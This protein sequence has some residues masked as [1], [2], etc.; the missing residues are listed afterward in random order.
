MK[1]QTCYICTQA[2]H[3]KTK[4]GLVRGCSC[5]GTAGFV[6]VSCLAEQAKILL[7]EAEEKNMDQVVKAKL[8]LRWQNCRLCGQL[9]NGV[10]GCALG[11]ACWKTYGTADASDI[12]YAEKLLGE[13]AEKA[14]RI[15]GPTRGSVVDMF[16]DLPVFRKIAAHIRA[17]HETP[18]YPSEV[19]FVVS[20]RPAK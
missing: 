19:R 8:W 3:W 17:T 4:E 2:L 14:R 6:H 18:P 11:W 20:R 13:N 1:G 16:R 9:Y 10:V 15:L 5:R 7:A 12:F